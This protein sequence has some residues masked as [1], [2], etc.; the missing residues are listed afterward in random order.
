MSILFESRNYR[1]IRFNLSLYNV[2]IRRR[3]YSLFLMTPKAILI[4][5]SVLQH[6][7]TLNAVGD[8]SHNADILQFFCS[9]QMRFDRS[10][11]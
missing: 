8:C 10:D 9:F 11:S 7:L 6:S 5:F 4:S 1:L 3:I 2:S